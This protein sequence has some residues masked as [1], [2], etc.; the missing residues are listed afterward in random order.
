MA[1]NLM[2]IRK[3]SCLINK[4]ILFFQLRKFLFV[5][6]KINISYG[7]I[8]INPQHISLGNNFYA[9]KG[10][11]LSTWPVYHK[12]LTGYTP[13]LIIGNNVSIM[14]YV[15]I[16]CLNKI[17]IED[18]CLIGDFVYISDNN[19]GDGHSELLVPPI[20]RELSS[21]GYIHIG[22]NVWIG[23]NVC[24]MQNVTIGEGSIIGANSVV[25]HNIPSYSLAVGS[26]A[27]VIKKLGDDLL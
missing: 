20:N 14:D 18:G 6:K 11:K 4:I 21:K 9:G 10:L 19:H 24:V 26:P 27:K 7:R 12:K 3:L 2:V 22:K 25:T 15:N 23:R 17:V 5:G 8:F 16:S 1:C 13:N